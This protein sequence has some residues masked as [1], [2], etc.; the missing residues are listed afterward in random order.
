M[1]RLSPVTH[2]AAV[3]ATLA[4]LTAPAARAA[5]GTWIPLDVGKRMSHTLTADP[6]RSRAIQFGGWDGSAAHS[7][8]WILDLTG[9]PQWAKMTPSGSAPGPRFE[10]IAVLDPTRDRM[11][12]FG[13]KTNLIYYGDLWSLDLTGSG[14]WS[15][16]AADG[17]PPAPMETRAIYDPVRDRLL[18]FGG[19]RPSAAVAELRELSLS[20]TPTWNDV[21]ANGT[22]PPA[23][24]GHTMIYDPFG[25]RVIVFGGYTGT[26]YLDDV[27]ELTLAGTP[28]WNQ[29]LPSGGPPSLRFGHSAIFDPQRLRM[30]VFG[31]FGFSGFQNDVWALN[32]ASP[33]WSLLTLDQGPPTARDFQ[34]LEYD[35]V[36][37]RAVMFGGNNN[38]G[39]QNDTWLID[40]E[41]LP[42]AVEV[43]AETPYASPDR[44]LLRWHVSSMVESYE[45]FRSEG[46]EVWQSLGS[47]RATGNGILAW[48]DRDVRVGQSYE[49]RL[50]YTDEGLARFGGELTVA[51]PQ[52]FRLA[53]RA[54][55]LVQDGRLTV[56]MTLPTRGDARIEV[57]DVSGRR[58][59]EQSEARDVGRHTVNLGSRWTPGVYWVRLQG[60]GA[61]AEQRIAI[62]R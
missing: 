3:L 1:R 46:G 12:V 43:S 32:L 53:L 27:W 50:R 45:V 40:L 9:Q 4:C 2:L 51:I 14:A 18:F 5:D 6:E 35:A 10:H 20:G 30:L 38:S 36:L 16:L 59:F 39:V 55:A 52:E 15:P 7:D 54:P 26:T 42:T 17:T 23:R 29:L 48:E 49:Y 24:Y 11:I 28:T 25:D 37:D 31:G 57:F 21:S 60:A 8:A 22:P 19:Y 62:L 41:N 44:V 47:A 33:S 56:E 34:A 58:V 61:T 13:G